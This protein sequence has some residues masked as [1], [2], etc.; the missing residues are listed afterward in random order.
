MTG[1]ITTCTGELWQLPSLK[2]W[3]V[4]HTDGS[5]CSCA[6][7]EFL[8]EPKRLPQLEQAVRLRLEE[9]GKTLFFGVVDELCAKSGKEGHLAT[10]SCR[11]MQALLM[12]NELRATEY[13]KLSFTDAVANFVTPFGV[14]LAEGRELPNLSN[15]AV[16][17]ATTPWQAL[18]GY[19]RHSGG[20]LPRFTRG[21]KLLF[22]AE[23]TA[24]R[25]LS[26]KN[27]VLEAELC[28]CRYGLIAEQLIV[29]AGKQTVEQERDETLL[30]AGVKTQKV[31][32]KQGKTLKADWRSARQRM[33][34]AKRQ[35]RILTVTLS[36]YQELEPGDR[37][38]ADLNKLGLAGEFTVQS[39]CH[40][41]DSMG[42][43][44]KLILEGTVA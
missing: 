29:T 6:E 15:F 34:D 17:T 38:T 22:S 42:K 28:L 32:M 8:L 25:C 12:D 30:A 26:E 31:T 1:Y 23:G 20:I 14:E 19:C 44:T 5:V 33:E 4:T 24:H 37:V 10:L 11:G 39:V 18:R 13:A 9:Q 7:V 40:S 3:Q 36:G 41:A 35:A 16:E 21:G 43:R 2:S 27:G